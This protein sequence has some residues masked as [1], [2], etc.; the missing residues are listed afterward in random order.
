MASK[1]VIDAVENRLAV[2]WTATPFLKPNSQDRPPTDGSAYLAVQFPTARETF[3]GMASVGNRTFREDG[4]VRFVLALPRALG[5]SDGSA[6]IETLRDLF[7]A[8]TISGVVF[9]E[10]Y[11]AVTDDRSNRGNY[12]VMAFVVPYYFD[13]FK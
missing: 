2:N 3:I 11:P 5:E 8:Q 4:T 6:N 7:R 13:A 10:A 1:S 12:W 9:E